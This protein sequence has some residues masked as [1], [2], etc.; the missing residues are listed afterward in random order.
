M[1][2]KRIAQPRLLAIGVTPLP[3]F[4]GKK[5]ARGLT[6]LLSHSGFVIQPVSNRYVKRFHHI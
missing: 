6:F 5:P 4:H 2:R 1:P 3:Q